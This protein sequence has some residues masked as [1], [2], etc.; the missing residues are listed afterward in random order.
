[1]K[2]DSMSEVAG[3]TLGAVA[4]TAFGLVVVHDH[5]WVAGW[6]FLGALFQAGSVIAAIYREAQPR[7]LEDK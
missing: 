4:N 6:L 3:E 2:T 5:V 1:M 7:Q